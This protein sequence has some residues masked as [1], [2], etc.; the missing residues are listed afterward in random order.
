MLIIASCACGNPLTISI[1]RKD[2]T[3]SGGKQRI[4][5]LIESYFKKGGFH[6][7][8]NIIDHDDLEKAK[9]NPDNHRD[10]VVRISGF[11]AN[12]VSIE[13]PW[14]DAIIERTKLGM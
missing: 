1:D 2:I 6:L 14:Q 8:F 3:N 11:S 9:L 5:Q 7:H 13:E 12:F 10:L 4:Q